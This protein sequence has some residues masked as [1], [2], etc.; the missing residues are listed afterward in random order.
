MEA[1]NGST[2]KVRFTEIRGGCSNGRA[3]GLLPH[4]GLHSKGSVAF[5]NNFMYNAKE[6][7]SSKLHGGQ[8]PPA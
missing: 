7:S 8:E 3:R 5:E 2:W 6:M 1:L 4:L